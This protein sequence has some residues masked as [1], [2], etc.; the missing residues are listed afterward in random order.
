MSYPRRDSGHRDGGAPIDTVPTTG[1]DLGPTGEHTPGDIMELSGADL[2]LE[3]ESRD[4][5]TLAATPRNVPGGRPTPYEPG[6]GH[7]GQSP[8]THQPSPL[9]PDEATAPPRRGIDPLAQTMPPESVATN[10]VGMDQQPELDASFAP[11]VDPLT[12]PMQEG[13]DPLDNAPTRI[14]REED[15]RASFDAEPQVGPRLLIIG[16]NNRGKE[17]PLKLGDNSIGR[18]VD[19]DIILADIAV[20][21]KHTLVCYEGNDFVVRDLGSGNGTLLNGKRVDAKPLADGDQLELGNTLMRFV[22]P[23]AVAAPQPADVGQLASMATVVTPQKHLDDGGRLTADIRPAKLPAPVPTRRERPSGPGL[24]ATRQRKLLVFGGLGVVL[25]LGGLI[26]LKLMLSAKKKQQVQQQQAKATRPPDELA[27]QEFQEGIAQYRI[28]SWEKARVHFLKVVKLVPTADHA[29]RYVDQAVAEIEAR[30]A[31]QRA[32]NALAAKDFE[33]ARKELIKIPSTSVYAPEAQQLKQKVDD[34]QLS[35]LLEVAR[36]LQAADDLAG[37]KAK[38]KEAMEIAPTNPEVVK[39]SSELSGE[40]KHTHVAAH[41]PTPRTT[42]RAHTPH[43][44]KPPAPAGNGGTIR[45]RGGKLKGVIALYK[46][47][48]WGQ[49]HK[50]AKD[51]AA[52][53]KGRAKKT[54]DAL[55]QAI[56]KV[57]MSWNRAQ[58][59]ASDEARLK[60]Y[61][62]ALQADR[63]IQRGIH[64]AA[65]KSLIVQAA[66]ASA[67]RAI[68]QRRYATAARAVKIAN[69]YGGSDPTLD[70]VKQVLEKKAM[71]MFTKGYTIRGTNVKQARQ[72]WQNVLKIVPPSSPAYQRAYQWLNNSSPSYQDED[73]D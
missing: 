17:Y 26:G 52:S 12:D 54:A 36:S 6:Y 73:E 51:L 31:L 23:S 46:Q 71:E 67:A 2:E 47:K 39:L 72:L 43:H 64:Q 34:Q 35:K 19:N 9:F 49:A 58:K 40:R 5:P 11:E 18:G 65:L 37:A 27:A 59:A 30:D 4:G 61:E 69:R 21:R 55:V 14:E 38:L 1:E 42:P 25:L 68:A 8:V 29:K 56:Y 63:K 48:Q 66:K 24:L 41:R 20:S 50:E 28:R 16:G 53:S 22:H 3:E 15:I 45:I 62:D 33:T 10:P 7:R 32:K 13:L 60:Y 70:R 57:G 44:P